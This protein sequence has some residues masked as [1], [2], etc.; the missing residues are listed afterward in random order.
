MKKYNE[1]LFQI[2]EVTKILGVTRKALLNYEEL[3]LLTPAVKDPES[4]Y[5]Y[6][7]ADNMTQIRS[8]KSLQQLGLS[9]K[10]VAEYYYNT[11]NIDN[12]L[13][14]LKDL[15]ANL[16]RNISMLEVRSAKR[17]ELTVKR[18]TLPQQVC[19]CRQ[20]ECADTADAANRLRDTYIAA[21]QTGKM[22]M[23]AR[24]FTMRMSQ[25]TDKIDLMCCI[26]VDSSFEGPERVEFPETPALCIYYRGPYTEFP[27][28]IKALTE[29]TKQNGIET[30]G[31][32]R[33]IY[34][35]GP[36][37]RGAKSE[38]YISQVAVPVRL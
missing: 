18:T 22:S 8:I 19:F 13:Q 10:E 27:I 21:A 1:S 23:V 25:A 2:G 36:P 14:R 29:Y 31:P 33:T 37:S 38:D 6:Y 7:T 32:F 34:Y 9:L 30:T 3:G 4:G 26:P 28:A 17:G 12:H 24:M 35:E 11:E 15:R 16:D 20:Y 5:R